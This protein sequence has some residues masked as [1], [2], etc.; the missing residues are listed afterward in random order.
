MPI[1]KGVSQG[2]FK[3][4]SPKTIYGGN[5]LMAKLC[6]ERLWLYLASSIVLEYQKFWD[7][8]HEKI[9]ETVR[10]NFLIKEAEKYVKKF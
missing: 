2:I 7:Y 9:F 6:D 4:S 8:C 10:A 3:F 1:V 5:K